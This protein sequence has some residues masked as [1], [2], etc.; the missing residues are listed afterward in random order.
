MILTLSLL[1]CS[2]SAS[3]YSGLS[4]SDANE[5][6]AVLLEKSIS[7]HKSQTKQGFSVDIR[8]A[9]LSAAVF[10]LK[11]KGLPRNS[12]AR[13]GDI[14]KKDGMVSTPVEE[15]GRYIYALSQELESSLSQIDGVVLARVHPVLQERSV[16]GGPI[17]P[18]SCSVLIKYRA[19]WSPDAYEDRIRK[20]VLSSI[21]GLAN[22]PSA[23]SIVFVPS[24]SVE[25]GGRDLGGSASSSSGTSA[26][27]VG[28]SLLLGLALLLFCMLIVALVRYRDALKAWVAARLLKNP[29]KQNASDTA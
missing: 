28:S 11:E 8:E 19:G 27:P 5:I 24:L 15:R 7:A 2:N 20:L 14:F 9:D 10:L 25:E 16:P 23:V 3:L 18:S 29:K 22:F 4:E 26:F 17:Q 12:F 1:G 21:P 13:M 6:V